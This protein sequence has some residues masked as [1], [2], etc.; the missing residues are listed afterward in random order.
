MVFTKFVGSNVSVLLHKDVVHATGDLALLHVC[1]IP[2]LLAAMKHSAV[3]KLNY[4]ALPICSP[5]SKCTLSAQD[6]W[7]N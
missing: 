3:S 1:Q 2:A 5:M 7:S 4:C 6:Q